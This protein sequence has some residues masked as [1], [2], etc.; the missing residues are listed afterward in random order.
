MS[1][2][3]Q[4]CL[5]DGMQELAAAVP[6]LARSPP[7]CELPMLADRRSGSLDVMLG[8]AA[9]VPSFVRPAD[10]TLLLPEE[11]WFTEET[12]EHAIDWNL[13]IVSLIHVDRPRITWRRDKRAMQGRA[14]A[15]PA[16]RPFALAWRVTRT[17]CIHWMTS[18]IA[19]GRRWGWSSCQ[20][21]R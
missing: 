9:S 13:P 11:R 12:A 8:L 7:L 4:L 1:G 2:D 15:R 3:P 18:W 14:I 21:T 6:S 16:R 5:A 19:S 20:R 10:I 17:R